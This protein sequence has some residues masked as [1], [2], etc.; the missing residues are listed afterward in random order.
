MRKFFIFWEDSLANGHILNGVHLENGIF[1]SDIDVPKIL[2]DLEKHRDNK[3]R[4]KEPNLYFVKNSV[5]PKYKFKEYVANKKISLHKT[6]RVKYAETFV[7]N[8]NAVKEYFEFSEFYEVPLTYFTKI[9]K[10]VKDTLPKDTTHVYEQIYS[11]NNDKTFPIVRIKHLRRSGNTGEMKDL[12]KNILPKINTHRF[13][14]DETLLTEINKEIII[15]IQ[16]YDNLK[17]MLYSKNKGDKNLA[18]DI[19][20]NSNPK[21]SKVY[22]ILLLAEFWKQFPDKTGQN[23]KSICKYFDVYVS[24][25]KMGYMHQLASIAWAHAISLLVDDELLNDE[26]NRIVANFV[27]NRVNKLISGNKLQKDL[28]KDLTLLN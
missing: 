13:I 11:H 20:A 26:E 18:V 9:I 7:I 5:L 16:M 12:I 4:P 17:T 19:I 25:I 22:I 27:K 1:E 28:I 21:E 24:A 23:F 2:G 10:Y 14:F 15:D 6:N 3:L 8:F